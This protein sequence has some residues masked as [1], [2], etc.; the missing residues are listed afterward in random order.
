[1]VFAVVT[2]ITCVARPIP[3]LERGVSN[4]PSPG[5]S[6]CS[7]IAMVLAAVM[8]C[9]CASAF[10][11][12]AHVPFSTSHR[13]S[14]FSSAART[15]LPFAR[16]PAQLRT[17]SRHATAGGLG[18]INMKAYEIKQDVVPASCPA[19]G[20]ALVFFSGHGDLRVHDHEGL[21]A[22]A[23]AAQAGPP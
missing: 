19:D 17:A 8:L 16:R 15:P 4:M 5:L 10:L 18:Q 2:W 7:G 14:H 11:A 23:S 22:A 1:M 6:A 3:S 12:P 13:K 20:K 21:A 9:D